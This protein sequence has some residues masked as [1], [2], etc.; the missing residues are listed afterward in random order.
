MA[1]PHFCEVLSSFYA[2]LQSRSDEHHRPGE[3]DFVRGLPAVHDDG[4]A[5]AVPQAPAWHLG[6]QGG[7]A[8]RRGG[9]S[10]P[11][12][13]RSHRCLRVRRSRSAVRLRFRVASPVADRRCGR[14]SSGPTVRIRSL[15]FAERDVAS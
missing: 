10:P 12:G 14:C 6:V 4:G 7:G 13:A 1:S 5:S 2:H 15:Y 11:H 8:R 9:E 3:P